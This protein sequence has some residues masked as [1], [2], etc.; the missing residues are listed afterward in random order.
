MFNII[1]TAFQKTVEKQHK[2]LGHYFVPYFLPFFHSAS[3]FTDKINS[4][5]QIEEDYV[6]RWEDAFLATGYENGKYSFL[7]NFVIM[8]IKRHGFVTRYNRDPS[9]IDTG[10]QRN[11]YITELYFKEQSCIP[12]RDKKGDPVIVGYTDP[13]LYLPDV[14]IKLLDLEFGYDKELQDAI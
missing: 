1:G 8:S 10:D 12:D 2:F 13:R 9:V 7:T 3:D 14:I 5:P 6:G 11:A 4:V